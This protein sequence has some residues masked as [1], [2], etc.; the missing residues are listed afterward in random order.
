[1]VLLPGTVGAAG[2]GGPVSLRGDRK[3]FWSWGM[4]GEVE[5]VVDFLANPLASQTRVDTGECETDTQRAGG[6]WFC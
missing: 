6:L 3:H 5:R 2:M 4:V 1:M